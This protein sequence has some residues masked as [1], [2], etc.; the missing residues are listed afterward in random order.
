VLAAL[1]PALRRWGIGSA[2]LLLPALMMVTTVALAITFSLIAAVA[3]KGAETSLRY[4]AERTGREIL[5]VPLRD[6]IKMKAKAYIDVAIEKGVGKVTSALLIM[7]LL[8]FM[9]YRHVAWVGAALAVCWFVLALAVRREFVHTLARSIHGRFASMN[10]VFT[11]IVNASTLPLLRRGLRDVSPLRVG[12]TLELLAQS[13]DDDVQPL[14]PELNALLAHDQ[15]EIRATALTQLARLPDALDVD[16]ARRLLTDDD[17][18]VR[19]AAVRALLAASGDTAPALLHELLHHESSTVRTAALAC[20]VGDRAPELAEA[21]RAYVEERWDRAD[22]TVEHRAELALAAG[23]LRD[24]PDSARYLDPFLDDDDLRVRS[25]ALRSA[26]L[27]GRLDCCPRMIAALGHPSTREAA[28]DALALIGAPVLEPL[29]RVLLDEAA[30]PA[31]RR[32]VPAT[33]VR[34]PSQATVDVMLE[35][36]LAPETD[37]LLD[38][39]TLK[40]LSKLRARHPDLVFDAG[41]VHSVASRECEAAVV[42]RSVYEHLEV[43]GRHS[44]SVLLRLALSEAF[45]ER[46]EGVFRCLGMLHDP[47]AVR[48]AYQASVRGSPAQRANAIEWLEHTLG[49]DR[50]VQ[51]APVLEPSRSTVRPAPT[52]TLTADGDA[53]VALLARAVTAPPGKDPVPGMELIEKVFLLQQVDL[54]RGARGAHV[55]LLASIAEEM[56]VPADS[57]LIPAGEPPEAMYIVTEGAVQLQGG[58]ERMMVGAEAAF[59]TWALIDE[60]PSVLEARAAEPTRLLRVT[61]HD[62]H[63]LLADHPELAIGMLQGLA[64]R[65]RSLVA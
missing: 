23:A 40:A 9:S 54:L 24:T 5:Y 43:T 49:H 30:P 31:I 64:R 53:W 27:L 18:G 3:A 48:R 57:V 36:V 38:Y 58:G 50:F 42:Y 22:G 35:L 34:L 39:R 19:E 11:S 51:L 52:T 20:I 45:E 55:A 41:L 7:L 33:L 8:Q 12:F 6:G 46:R 29:A 65:M 17:S 1:R 28:R 47:D 62:F 25:T 2:V 14:A 10:G 26:A 59:G 61:R 44:P 37:Q 56:A 13:T 16:G 63:D 21:G 4:S 15:A 32:A 60:Q